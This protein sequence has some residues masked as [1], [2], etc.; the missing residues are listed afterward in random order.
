[1]DYSAAAARRPL[2]V[3]PNRNLLSVAG[4]KSCEDVIWSNHRG[5]FFTTFICFSFCYKRYCPCAIGQR[6]E[7]WQ[8][9]RIVD[10]GVLT[11]KSP[12]E[13]ASICDAGTLSS[14]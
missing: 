6:R 1:M 8:A 14:Y 9:M 12:A 5:T 2:G 13:F 7:V 3:S 11:G 10:V 4:Q